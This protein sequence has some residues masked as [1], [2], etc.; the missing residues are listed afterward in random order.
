MLVIILFSVL[1]E[2]GQLFVP[3]VFFIPLFHLSELLKEFLF[4]HCFQAD[5]LCFCIYCV[6]VLVSP[7]MCLSK[8]NRFFVC[9]ALIIL[10]GFA[11]L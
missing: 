10:V 4:L 9:F 11:F 1:F 5:N 7:D 8:M 3:E 2:K 6:T